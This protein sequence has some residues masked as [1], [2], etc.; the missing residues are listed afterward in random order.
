M[1]AKTSKILWI[2]FLA[3]ASQVALQGQTCCTAGMPVSS[4]LDIASDSASLSFQ[5]RY[6]YKSINA[7]I[8]N[9]RRLENDPRSRSGQNLSLKVDY[10]LN[11]SWAISA[12]LPLIKHNRSTTSEMQSSLGLGDL[13]FLAQYT[14]KNI[15]L[16]SGLKL[17]TGS[18]N[19]RANNSLLLSPDMQ[20]GSGSYD[21]LFRAVY[22]LTIPQISFL[23][24]SLY[25][26]YRIN[27]TN[28]NFASTD[29][30]TGRRFGFGN[31]YLAGLNID[32]TLVSPSGFFIPNF[33]VQY[34]HTRPN[35]E[36]QVLAPNS[37]GSWINLMGGI[38]YS[39]DGVK[40]FAL[41][42]EVPLYQNLEGL[43][44]TSDYSIGIQLSYNVLTNKK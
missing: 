15:S 28:D 24:G 8:D 33:G 35:V 31:E 1:S 6:E 39:I 34:R 7:L 37:G 44:I 3:I 25:S 9:N 40:T 32:Y 43:Q 5:L 30:F 38:A 18:T 20:S 41:F 21:V 14:Y 22:N 19:K 17:P 12:I 16:I 42:T 23:S 4:V 29:S 27:N 13:V 36:Q 26:S 2:L 11:Q 10:A